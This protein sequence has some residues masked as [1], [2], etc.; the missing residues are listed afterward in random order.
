[1]D[2]AL[3]IKDFEEI[4]RKRIPKNAYDYYRSGANAG[5]SLREGERE[6]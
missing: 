6:Y 3:N 2:K 5:I 4:A 1:M